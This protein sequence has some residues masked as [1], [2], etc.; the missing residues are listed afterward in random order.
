MR[1]S[2]LY[3]YIVPQ[4]GGD[5]AEKALQNLKGKIGERSIVTGDLNERLTKWDRVTNARGRVVVKCATKWN[6]KVTPPRSASY[7]A[8]GRDGESTPNLLVGLEAAEVTQPKDRVWND[9]SDHTP[10]LYTVKNVSIKVGKRRIS[11]TML[12]NQRNRE[13]AGKWYREKTPELTKKVKAVGS[14]GAQAIYKE[15]TIF[16]T[17]PW[18]R[19]TERKPATR[20]PHWNSGLQ[21][22]WEDLRKARMRASKSGLDTDRELFEAKRK[23][24]QKANRRRRRAFERNTENLLQKCQNEVLSTVIPKYRRRRQEKDRI[25]SNSGILLDSAAFTRFMGSYHDQN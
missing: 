23:E 11:K 1:S 24:F 6:Y 20:S 16:I 3:S 15:V 18:V 13:E 5:S 2:D 4:T 21:M 9:S 8:R 19:M 10:I 17:E 7:K 12:C 25:L 14:E 22:R